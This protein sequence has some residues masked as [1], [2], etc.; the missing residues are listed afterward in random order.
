[1]DSSERE[2]SY[3]EVALTNRQVM[4]AF[5]VLLACLFGAFFAGV[6]FGQGSRPP[7]P[8]AQAATAPAAGSDKPV[9]KLTFFGDT[10]G[11]AAPTKTTPAPQPGAAKQAAV[12][13][14]TPADTEADK[15][16]R[17]LEAEMD[18]N[19]EEPQAA[20]TAADSPAAGTRIQRPPAETPAP[21]APAKSVETPSTQAVAP[22][23]GES[24][25]TWIQVY[26]STNG[27]R[28]QQLVER[29]RKSGF[30]VHLLKSPKGVGTTYRVRVGPYTT[31]VQ[32]D[33]DAAR[34]RRD[35]RL[36]TWVTDQ[37]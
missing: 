21:P 6:W 24:A 11:D 33:R 1:L 8:A 2:P 16:R 12:A 23:T 19:R 22:A 18:A 10:G 26:S 35:F 20:A 29:L 28:A 32:A 3:Y 7:Q 31:R 37:P 4:M 34:L 25:Q 5:V 15:L 27:E 9:E 14:P 30:S 17:T 13:A 36:D